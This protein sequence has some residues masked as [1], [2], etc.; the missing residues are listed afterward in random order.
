MNERTTSPRL[1]RARSR[2][3]HLT[4]LARVT[5]PTPSSRE[6]VDGASL[7]RAS[8]AV[9]ISPSTRRRVTS[10]SATCSITARARA[11]PECSL[12]CVPRGRGYVTSHA[13]VTFDHFT[14]AHH[15]AIV[16]FLADRLAPRSFSEIRE[17]R[18]RA[19]RWRATVAL[20]MRTLSLQL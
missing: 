12:W 18:R 16:T 6:V 15:A 5:L 3:S 1:A 19:R 17:G 20:E 7:A 13:E 9:D 4:R 14:H 11:N 10:H 8:T 2:V